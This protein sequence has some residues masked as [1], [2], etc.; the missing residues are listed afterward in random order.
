MSKRR[1][2]T[3]AE[4]V[5]SNDSSR[6]LPA[7]RKIIR[8]HPRKGRLFAAACCYRICHLLADQRSLAAIH[9]AEQYAEGLIGEEQL[10]A[11][12]ALATAAYNRAA[13]VKGSVRSCAD[14]AAHYVAAASAWFAATKASSYAYIATGDHGLER[15]RSLTCSAASSVRSHSAM[16][17]SNLPG[18]PPTSRPSPRLSILMRVRPVAH[19][20]RCFRGFRLRAN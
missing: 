19:P 20:C 15:Q 5:A 12:E 1:R 16:C 10:R 3:E 18:S 8:E 17:L 7:C 2:L 11:A 14:W 9:L 13:R 6:M 4:R